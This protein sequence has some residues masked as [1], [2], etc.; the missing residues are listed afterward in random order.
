MLFLAQA[1]VET[2]H[3]IAFMSTITNVLIWVQ[4]QR[5]GQRYNVPVL[6]YR[7]PFEYACG[8]TNAIDEQ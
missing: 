1:A 3:Y 8:S 7:T 4:T 5:M 2:N 6:R